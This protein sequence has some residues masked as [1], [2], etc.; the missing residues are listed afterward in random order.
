MH[1]VHTTT[2]NINSGLSQ[3]T[4]RYDSHSFTSMREMQWTCMYGQRTNRQTHTLT[5]GKERLDHKLIRI[6]EDGAATCTRN[7][8][9]VMFAGIKY[10]CHECIVNI[11]TISSVKIKFNNN[12]AA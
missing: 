12:T 1:S 9:I 4:Q 7:A 8:L 11:Y 6:M 3:F 5:D 2:Q 10:F